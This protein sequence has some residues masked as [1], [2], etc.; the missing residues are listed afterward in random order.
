MSAAK[1]APIWI[2][3]ALTIDPAEIEETFV[4]AIA[5]PPH[6]RLNRAVFERLGQKF[7]VPADEIWDALFPARRAG[8]Y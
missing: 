6:G 4:L 2:S 7:G 1:A 8:R 3:G 5:R